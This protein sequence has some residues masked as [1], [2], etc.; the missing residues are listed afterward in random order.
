MPV[1]FNCKEEEKEPVLDVIITF[2]LKEKL[3][4]VLVIRELF[5]PKTQ[6]IS[7]VWLISVRFHLVKKIKK[8]TK[9]KGIEYICP[10]DKLRIDKPMCESG[11]RK[12]SHTNLNML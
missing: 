2:F 5:F 3:T 10:N 1:R 6:L 4:A 12:N 8:P 11:S 7:I 9:K